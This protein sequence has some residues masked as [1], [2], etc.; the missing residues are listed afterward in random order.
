MMYEF[1]YDEFTKSWCWG[2][3]E[4]G[5]VIYRDDDDSWCWNMR[6]KIATSA[7]ARYG[8]FERAKQAAIW[9]Y[10]RKR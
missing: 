7:G 3:G 2:S 4:D 1:T 9:D 6:N 8:S 5:I 10:E